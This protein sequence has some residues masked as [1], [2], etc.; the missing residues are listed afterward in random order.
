[1]PFSALTAFLLVGLFIGKEFL[2]T[3]SVAF[4]S[5]NAYGQLL[6]WIVLWVCVCIECRTSD[7]AIIILRGLV[8]A[9]L[10][11]AASIAYGY[12]AGGPNPYADDGVVASAGWFSTAKT[13]TGVLLTGAVLL[14]YLGAR[15]RSFMYQSLAIVCCACC[16]ITYARAGQVA[17]GVVLMWLVVWC[18]VKRAE[19]RATTVARF[20]IAMAFLA[21]ISMPIMLRSQSFVNRWQDVHD[22]DKGG[23]G[24]AD[25]W[26]IALEDYEN[27]KPAELVF[28]FG[29]SRMDRMLF[30]DCGADIHHTHNDLLDVMLLGGVFGIAWWAGLMITFLA[31]VARGL[32]KYEGMASASIFLIF[33]F[34]GQLTGQ[35]MGT[36][37]MV[38]Y[39]LGI[40]SLYIIGSDRSLQYVRPKKMMIRREAIIS[41]RQ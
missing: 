41:C 34:H 28:G 27:A 38:M 2:D 4:S 19:T 17:L 24:R 20:L 15:R 30:K 32:R 26:R 29:Y 39:S 36:D 40:T 23:S 3:G 33:A 16:V 11:S 31:Y 21:A 13:I 7:D 6:Y 22:P 10:L 9:A 37:A 14:L 18:V 1:V 25:F 12:Y 35:L 8:A 5:V